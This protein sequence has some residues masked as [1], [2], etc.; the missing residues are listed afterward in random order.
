MLQKMQ[1]FFGG[2]NKYFKLR[3]YLDMV[4]SLLRYVQKELKSKEK[5]PLKTDRYRWVNFYCRTLT[6]NYI[7]AQ[8]NQGYTPTK[9]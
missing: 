7:L 4:E 2:G 5:N 8:K 1:F 6:A 9:S 3:N